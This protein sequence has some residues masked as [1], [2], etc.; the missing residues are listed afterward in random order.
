MLV[1]ERKLC[2]R[3]GCSFLVV[4]CKIVVIL[5]FDVLWKVRDLNFVSRN[6]WASEKQLEKQNRPP[7]GAIT[8]C[9]IHN[10]ALGTL[11]RLYY[12]ATHHSST[13]AS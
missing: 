13:V 1:I 5:V 4:R 2:V 3:G 6:F 10:N 11:A 12:N 8:V 7:T 9:I